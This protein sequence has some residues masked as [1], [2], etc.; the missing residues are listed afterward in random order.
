MR[1]GALPQLK[2]ADEFKKTIGSAA[3]VL[4]EFFGSRCQVCT[5]FEPTVEELAKKY[6]KVKFYRVHII[7]F[8][9][10]SELDSFFLDRVVTH[11]TVIP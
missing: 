1:P 8:I 11:E 6:P 9:Y 3:P 7:S 10:S 4:V 5:N 2:S